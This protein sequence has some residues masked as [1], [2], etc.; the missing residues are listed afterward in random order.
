M[1]LVTNIP[2]ADKAAASVFA[3]IFITSQFIGRH[4]HLYNIFIFK[5]AA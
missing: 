5:L 1:T 3:N 4:F 2:A